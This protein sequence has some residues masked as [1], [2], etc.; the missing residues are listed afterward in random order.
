MTPNFMARCLSM[1]STIMLERTRV[2]KAF[3][4]QLRAEKAAKQEEAVKSLTEEFEDI[5]VERTSDEE[6]HKQ[7][8][9]ER[10]ALEREC[11]YDDA[12]YQ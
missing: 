11:A 6:R 9:L 5:V 2:R 3:E 1:N 4:A 12:R 10:L 7:A 8:F